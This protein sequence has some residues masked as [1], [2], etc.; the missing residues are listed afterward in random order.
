MIEVES[1]T[2]QV[3]N[4]R[5]EVLVAHGIGSNINLVLYDPEAH[6]AGMMNIMLPHSQSSVETAQLMPLL[7]A[8]TGIVNLFRE[9]HAKGGRLERT[10][11]YVCGASN[12]MGK[13]DTFSIGKRNYLIL[14]KIFLKNG[15]EI[16]G[17]DVGGSHSRNVYFDLGQGQYSV[18]SKLGEKKF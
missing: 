18:R 9:F 14:R 12:I 17:E 13:D 2:M 5:E 4:N 15:I 11:A 8:D 1:H 3:S 6:V 16:I 10:K 7:Y